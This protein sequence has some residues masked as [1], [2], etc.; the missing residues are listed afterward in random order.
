VCRAE[1]YVGIVTYRTITTVLVL[2]TC[3]EFARGQTAADIPLPLRECAQISNDPVRLACYDG[4]IRGVSPP[5]VSPS[6]DLGRWQPTEA[7]DAALGFRQEPIQGADVDLTL[8]VR[9]RDDRV[10]LHLSRNG[11]LAN[12]ASASVTMR[13]DDRLIS[14]N[15]WTVSRDARSATLTDDARAL[16]ERLPERGILEIRI[17]GSSRFRFEGRYDLAGLAGIRQKLLR[18]CRR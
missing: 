15:L 14:S 5:V 12:S 9:C 6:A 7:S 4:L 11:P 18:Q 8:E 16:L 10:S 13:A 1:R 3:S 2:L 17:E